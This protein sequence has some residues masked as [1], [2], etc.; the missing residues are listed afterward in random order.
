MF[1][2]FGFAQ[3]QGIRKRLVFRI[4]SDIPPEV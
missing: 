1:V 4:E 2:E 3:H